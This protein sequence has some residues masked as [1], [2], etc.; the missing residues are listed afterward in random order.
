MILSIILPAHSFQYN[1]ADDTCLKKLTAAVM[2]LSHLI[3][4]DK[5]PKP[6]KPAHYHYLAASEPRTAHLADFPLLYRSR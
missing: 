4:D 1:T 3:T 5:G 6:S 2:S